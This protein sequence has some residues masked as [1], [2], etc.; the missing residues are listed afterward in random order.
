MSPTKKPYNDIESGSS[1]DG[2]K[3]LLP[4]ENQV[5]SR[6]TAPTSRTPEAILARR[7]ITI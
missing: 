4:R 1:G 3:P 5:Q 2:T 6:N 7:I